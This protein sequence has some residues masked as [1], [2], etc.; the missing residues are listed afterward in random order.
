MKLITIQYLRG[1]ASFLVLIEHIAWKGKQYLGDPLNWFHIGGAG[2]DIFFIISGF[3]MCHTTTARHDTIQGVGT[4]LKKR[5]L[6]IM[7]LYWFLTIIALL[8]F[9]IMPHRINTGGGETEIIS[10]FL[11]LPTNGSFL[12]KNG[13]TLSYEYYFYLIF[14]IGLIFNEKIGRSLV[15]VLLILLVIIGHILNNKGVYSAFCFNLIL[16]EFIMGITLYYL[17]K[18]FVSIPKAISLLLVSI[19]ITFF[20]ILNNAEGICF[21]PRIIDY[22]IPAFIFCSGIVLMENEVKKHKADILEKLGDSSYSLYLLHP[23]VLSGFIVFLDLLHIDKKNYTFIIVFLMFIVSLISG[24]LCYSHI[25][26]KFDQKL[27][28]IFFKKRQMDN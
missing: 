10:S 11:L 17:F 9:I 4:F 19:S 8:I 7:P 14:S 5:V 26:R 24:Y 15:T 20:V 23:F 6:R 28:V 12:L 27:R 18:L 2:V 1:F 21:G 16:L 25:E 22:G 13:W 3:I